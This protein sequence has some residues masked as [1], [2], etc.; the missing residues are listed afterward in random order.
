MSER[1]WGFKSPLAHAK[2]AGQ[3]GCAAP[4]KAVLLP[5]FYRRVSRTDLRYL[6]ATVLGYARPTRSRVSS[7]GPPDRPPSAAALGHRHTAELEHLYARHPCEGSTGGEVPR[8]APD[9]RWRGAAAPV[10]V[11]P[12]LGRERLGEKPCCPVDRGDIEELAGPDQVLKRLRPQDRAGAPDI[13]PSRR[14]SGA[15]WTLPA[16]LTGSRRS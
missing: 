2:S 3:R 4:E 12:L 1:M 9:E 8:R 7:G 6:V 5:D 10:R 16:T 11:S 15:C 13:R 14:L